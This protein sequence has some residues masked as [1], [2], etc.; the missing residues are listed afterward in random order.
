MTKDLFKTL[1]IR[2]LNK[3]IVSYIFFGVCTTLVNIFAYWACAHPLNLST[4]TSN[5]IAWVTGVLF[6]YFTNRTWV[7]HSDTTCMKDIIIEIFFFFSCRFGTGIIDTI[8]MY[9][10]IDILGLN[11]VVIK[12][13]SNMIVIVLNYLASKLIIFKKRS[14]N[15]GNNSI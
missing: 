8:I 2:F 15:E 9:V 13:I 1:I 4:I 14:E 3:E 11:D 6:A 5:V 12:V 7:F 10:F